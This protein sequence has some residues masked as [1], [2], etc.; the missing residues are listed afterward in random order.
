MNDLPKPPPRFVPT[1]TEVV[2]PSGLPHFAVQNLPDVQALVRQVQQHIQPLIEQKLNA[3]LEGLVHAVHVT[4][5]QRWDELNS[6]LQTDI[7]ASIQQAVADV[8]KL[9][10][11]Q[12]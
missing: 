6:Q 7:N 2:D 9:G 4:L 11:T 5:S 8:L 1:L 3:E 12:K 10:K